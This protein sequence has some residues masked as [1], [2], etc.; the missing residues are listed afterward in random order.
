MKKKYK[1]EQ[2][3]IL[4]NGLPIHVLMTD[5]SGRGIDTEEDL[6]AFM[7]IHG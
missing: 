4:D 5:Y 2:L 3:R 6:K 1:L 7:E